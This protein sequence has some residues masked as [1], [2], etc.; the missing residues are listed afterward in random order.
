MFNVICAGQCRKRLIG[1][2]DSNVLFTFRVPD[3][4][5]TSPNYKYRRDALRKREARQK[6]DGWECEQCRNVS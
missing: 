4:V 5:S 2:Q 3:K 1:F 6:L